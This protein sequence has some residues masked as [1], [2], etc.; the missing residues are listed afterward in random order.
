MNVPDVTKVDEQRLGKYRSWILPPN[1]SGCMLWSRCVNHGGYGMFSMKPYRN[2][3]WLTHRLMWEITFGPI[4]N[5]MLV[6]HKCDVPACCNPEHLFLGTPADNMKDMRQ[7]GRHQYGESS[8]R[9]RLTDNKVIWARRA[10]RDGRSIR[11]IAEEL[12]VS[13]RTAGRAVIGQTWR[14]LPVLSSSAK[15]RGRR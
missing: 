5:G 13:I 12:G 3:F 8:H 14:H 6:C 4:P 7:K 10:S 1:E 2:G 11:Q 9:A 15:T